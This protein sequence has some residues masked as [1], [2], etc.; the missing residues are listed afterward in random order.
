MLVLNMFRNLL[1]LIASS[2]RYE[3]SEPRCKKRLALAINEEGAK[4]CS[5]RIVVEEGAKVGL[6]IDIEQFHIPNKQ[7]VS[8]SARAFNNG[9][10]S[11]HIKHVCLGW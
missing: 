10:F 1:V 2:Q 11:S 3:R 8:L 4:D 5:C 6:R 9:R 7:M